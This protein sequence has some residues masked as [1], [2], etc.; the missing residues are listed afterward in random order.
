MHCKVQSTPLLSTWD[1]SPKIQHLYKYVPR[2]AVRSLRLTSAAWIKKQGQQINFYYLFTNWTVLLHGRDQK[3]PAILN[4][5]PP[6]RCCVQP[7]SN[8]LPTSSRLSH[9]LQHH[10]T[11]FTPS[12][13]ASRHCWSKTG[14]D[15]HL[16]SSTGCQERTTDFSCKA[17]SF[18]STISH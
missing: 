12:M 5:M 2:V 9:V 14:M 13:P 18:Q 10:L 17:C 16:P 1:S 3:I 11:A 6:S 7:E 15:D 8:Q 4:Q